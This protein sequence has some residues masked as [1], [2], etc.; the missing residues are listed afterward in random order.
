MKCD[1]DFT[2]KNEATYHYVCIKSR[3]IWNVGDIYK[4]KGRCDKHIG[5][6]YDTETWKLEK[7]NDES[8]I[9]I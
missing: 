9:N 6:I 8:V 3:W 2:C 1:F 5:E 7:I 4:L